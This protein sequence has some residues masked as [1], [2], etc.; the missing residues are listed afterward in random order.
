MLASIAVALA[1]WTLVEPLA[2]E[3]ILLA[4]PT[5][6]ILGLVAQAGDLAI[7][8]YKRDAVAKDSGQALPGFGGTGLL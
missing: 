2:S 4:I 5:G 6:I 3:S 7:S 1:G 8:L